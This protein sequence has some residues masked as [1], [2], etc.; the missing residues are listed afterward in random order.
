MA[1]IEMRFSVLYS[2][3]AFGMHK[4]HLK[5]HT[6]SGDSGSGWEVEKSNEN[7]YSRLPRGAEFS[8]G[9]EFYRIW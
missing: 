2:K 1:H 6:Y 9:I 8:S 3:N 5:V 7:R 4:V